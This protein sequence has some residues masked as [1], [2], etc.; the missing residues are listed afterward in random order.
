MTTVARKPAPKFYAPALPG[1]D[2]YVGYDYNE[3]DESGLW[4]IFGAVSGHAYA[5]FCDEEEANKALTG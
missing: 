3:E 4:Y 5:S 2:R 1:E